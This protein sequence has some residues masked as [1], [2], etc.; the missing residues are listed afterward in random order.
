MA[1]RLETNETIEAGARIYL[2][3]MELGET[4]AHHCKGLGE[5]LLQYIIYI[6]CR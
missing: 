4:G 2:N 3:S 1:S 6:A 5:E